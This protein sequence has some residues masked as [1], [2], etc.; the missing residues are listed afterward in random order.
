[1]DCPPL[2]RHILSPPRYEAPHAYVVP[3][4][5]RYDAPPL[6]SLVNLDKITD[7][8]MIELVKHCPQLQSLD[9]SGCDKITD[10]GVTASARIKKMIAMMIMMMMC[11]M[12]TQIYYNNY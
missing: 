12:L 10:A 3:P 1:M 5:Y 8:G 11:S 4:S 7:A 2:G 6:C 9:L